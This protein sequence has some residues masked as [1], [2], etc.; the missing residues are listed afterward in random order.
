MFAAIVSWRLG[1]RKEYLRAT[2][3]LKNPINRHDNPALASM[4]KTYYEDGIT[5]IDRIDPQQT[6]LLLNSVKEV[7]GDAIHAFDSAKQEDRWVTCVDDRGR[8]WTYYTL[9]GQ[10]YIDIPNGDNLSLCGAEYD[11]QTYTIQRLFE[12]HPHFQKLLQ[13]PLLLEFCKYANCCDITPNIL[14]V[15]RRIHASAANVISDAFPH[16]DDTRGMVKIYL[17][18]N[19]VDETNAPFAISKGSHHWGWYP[20]LLELLMVLKIKMYTPDMIRRCGINPFE[21]YFGKAGTLLGISTNAVHRSTNLEEGKERWTV[22]LIYYL[23]DTWRT[24]KIR[25]FQDMSLVSR[26]RE[27]FAL[28]ASGVLVRTINTDAYPE[29]DTRPKK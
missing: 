2:T 16:V 7:L 17:Y 22:Q 11:A 8:H 10:V 6:T 15:D 14:R 25:N 23:K 27:T 13:H 29:V 3:V 26:L 21:F 19:D 5:A 1:G 24:E 9:G 12:D 4:F 28:P 20:K 18:L